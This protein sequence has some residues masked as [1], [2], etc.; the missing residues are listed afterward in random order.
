MAEN[1]HALDVILRLDCKQ[2]NAFFFSYLRKSDDALKGQRTVARSTVNANQWLR[3]IDTYTSLSGR[4]FL[5]TSLS[6]ATIPFIFSQRR[7]FKAIK[8]RHP[9]GFSYIK[10]C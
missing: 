5:Y 1:C 7:G 4:L 8:L 6:G 9:L 3:S 10:T 2:F